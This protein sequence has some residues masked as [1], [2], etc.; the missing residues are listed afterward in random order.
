MRNLSKIIVVVLFF[1]MTWSL[2]CI[3]RSLNPNKKD[4]ELLSTLIFHKSLADVNIFI[5]VDTLDAN[6]QWTD[7]CVMAGIHVSA[8]DDTWQEQ[9]CITIANANANANAKQIGDIYKTLL[10]KYGKSGFQLKIVTDS[11]GC[12]KIYHR[13]KGIVGI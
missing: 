12:K 3:G 1:M 13:V 9:E 10:S 11:T 5:E 4:V 2:G 8:P 7:F 6:W